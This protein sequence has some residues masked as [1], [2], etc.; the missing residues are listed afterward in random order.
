MV[1]CATHT[2]DIVEHSHAWLLRLRAN[3]GR[4]SGE[5]IAYVWVQDDFIDPVVSRRKEQLVHVQRSVYLR[6]D[7]VGYSTQAGLGANGCI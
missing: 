4:R 5:R 1:M 7:A 6:T 2:T 3:M